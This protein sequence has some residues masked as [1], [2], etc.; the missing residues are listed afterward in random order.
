MKILIV[1]YRPREHAKEKEMFAGHDVVV[2]GNFHEAMNRMRGPRSADFRWGDD[3]VSQGM[4]REDKT[5]NFDVVCA[6]LMLRERDG[7]WGEKGEEYSHSEFLPLGFVVAIRAAMCGAK[8]AIVH[9]HGRFEEA[10]VENIGAHYSRHSQPAG[11]LERYRNVG[12]SLSAE[13]PDIDVCGC[14]VVFM[15]IPA[16]RFKDGETECYN[17]DG[18]GR[19]RQCA[20]T[21]KILREGMFEAEKCS[22][23]CA[24]RPGVCGTC[25]G[26]GLVDTH[27]FVKDWGRVVKDLM[28]AKIVPISGANS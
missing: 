8:I 19:C 21:G 3:M 26:T 4:M 9:C 10:V 17:C 2:V 7:E 11:K 23:C 27:R 24:E 14:R 25:Q 18:R 15:K 22:C 6:D 28:A 20:G 13:W 5:E 12:S 16:H 1:E